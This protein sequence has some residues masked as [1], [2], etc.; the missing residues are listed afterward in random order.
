[1]SLRKWIDRPFDIDLGDGHGLWFFGW[2]PDRELNP[3]YADRPDIDR[4]G[5][6]LLHHR[7]DGVECHSSITFDVPGAA[8]I[9]PG[10]AVWSVISWEPLTVAPSIL[11]KAPLDA[12]GFC[13]DH[14]FIREGAWVR[15]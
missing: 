2:S 14:G 5:A 1:M 12:G 3:Q 8:E 15:A 4:L 6:I 9:S 13:G 7:A 11:C 10:R